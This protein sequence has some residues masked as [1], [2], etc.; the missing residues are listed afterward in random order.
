MCHDLLHTGVIGGHGGVVGSRLR[1]NK[2]FERVEL[3][4]S[5]TFAGSEVQGS[6]HSI[7]VSR[8]TR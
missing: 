4:Y 3:T 8:G 5:K 2:S 1:K 7:G 6:L